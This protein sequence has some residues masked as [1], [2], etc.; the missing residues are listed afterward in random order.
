MAR[1]QKRKKSKSSSKNN[2]SIITFFTLIGLIL[3]L[4]LSYDFFYHK[5][6]YIKVPPALVKKVE[7]HVH[8]NRTYQP[9]KVK[10][11]PEV[12]KSPSSEQADKSIRE[13]RYIPRTKKK[14]S[15]PGEKNFSHVPDSPVIKDSLSLRDKRPKVAIVIDDLGINKR[16]AE[17][18]FQINEE[19]TFSILPERPFSRWTAQEGHKRGYE[20]MAHIP[21]EPIDKKNKMGKGGLYT[22]MTDDKIKEIFIHNIN[23]IPYIVGFN[24]HMGSAFTQDKRAMKAVFSGINGKKLFFLDSVTTS[25]SIAASTAKEHGV[26]TYRR[27]I[28]LDAQTD[29]QFIESQWKKVVKVANKKGQAIA[30]GHPHKNTILFLSNNLPSQHVTIVPLSEITAMR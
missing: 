16:Q 6:S 13:A 22:L 18:L 30:I 7:N 9:L 5:G 8:I 19:L 24:N 21:M 27:D 15:V 17:K 23:S 25:Q 3:L 2:Y 29:Y 14:Q 28:F 4:S 11:P 26:I 12:N 20:I 1:S 10:P